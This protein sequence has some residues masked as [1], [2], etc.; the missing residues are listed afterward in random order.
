MFF[1]ENSFGFWKY[2][3]GC[4]LTLGETYF[5]FGCMNILNKFFKVFLTS[6]ALFPFASTLALASGECSDGEFGQMKRENNKHYVCDP[7]LKIW[8]SATRMEISLSKSCTPKNL[9]EKMSLK[10]IEVTCREDDWEAIF[11]DSRD[12]RKYSVSV[13]NNQVWMKENLD[14][15]KMFGISCKQCDGYHIYDFD[16]AQKVCPKGWRL[17]SLDEW[18]YVETNGGLESVANTGLFWSATKVVE[19]SA[20]KQG[21]AA[22]VRWKWVNDGADRVQRFFVMQQSLPRRNGYPVRCLTDR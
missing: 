10:N 12:K 16:D 6:A 15:E 4:A 1:A 17:P 5:I 2:C 19:P 9:N 11:I 21:Y 13:I 18:R 22:D 20:V 3:G 8:R 14:Y 7:D